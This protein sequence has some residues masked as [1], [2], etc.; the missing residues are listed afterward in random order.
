[1]LSF[2]INE[3]ELQQIISDVVR[4]VLKTELS[5]LQEQTAPE[6]EVLLKTNEVADLLKVSP[7]TV[8]LWKRDGKIPYRKIGRLVFYDKTDVLN[9]VKS[10]QNVQM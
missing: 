5:N 1:M 8:K 3:N 10:F 9:S 4:D 2:S 7:L 6:K